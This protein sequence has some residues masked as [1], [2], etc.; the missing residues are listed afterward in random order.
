MCR[1]CLFSHLFRLKPQ[2]SVF[3]VG[4]ITFWFLNFF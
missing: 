3:Y 1:T 4:Q 2:V